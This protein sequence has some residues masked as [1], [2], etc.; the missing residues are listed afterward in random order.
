VRSRTGGHFYLGKNDEC[1]QQIKGPILCL[2]SIINH[3]MSSSAE[4]E[5][6]STFNNAK[7]AAPLQVVLEV[8]GHRQPPLQFKLTIQQHLEF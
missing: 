8:M 4:A 6:E 1:Q 5:V 2:L 7:E 3:I